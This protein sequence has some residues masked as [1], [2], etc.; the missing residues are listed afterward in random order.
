VQVRGGSAVG[1][2]AA[3]GSTK[4]LVLAPNPGTVTGCVTFASAAPVTA[5]RDRSLRPVVSRA[6][7]IAKRDA[8]ESTNNSPARGLGMRAFN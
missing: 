4:V 3:S 1:V 7:L 5:S 2:A 8:G 6:G